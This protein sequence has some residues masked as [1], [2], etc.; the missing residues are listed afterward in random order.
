MVPLYDAENGQTDVRCRI[1][2][3]TNN[4]LV[5]KPVLG[6][7]NWNYAPT[8]DIHYL[9]N[10]VHETRRKCIGRSLNRVMRNVHQRVCICVIYI[11]VYV[12]LWLST[13]HGGVSCVMLF[14]G[15]AADFLEFPYFPDTCFWSCERVWFQHSKLTN[16]CTPSSLNVFS[17]SRWTV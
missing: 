2:C 8:C 10:I 3:T 7:V 1:S 13:K 15:R 6:T 11:S 4:P 14:T 12:Y 17:E 9:R 5:M 16:T